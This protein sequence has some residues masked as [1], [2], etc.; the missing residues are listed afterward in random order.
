MV[1]VHRIAHSLQ[2]CRD[3]AHSH[4]GNG[5][6]FEVAIEPICLPQRGSIETMLVSDSSLLCL[7]VWKTIRTIEVSTSCFSLVS[8]RDNLRKFETPILDVRN[9]TF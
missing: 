4:A 3:V 6:F 8:N 9:D 2:V 5:I 7:L 1:I